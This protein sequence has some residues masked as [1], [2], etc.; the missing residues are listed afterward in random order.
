MSTKVSACLIAISLWLIA[1]PT[2]A[3]S[4]MRLRASAPPPPGY[5][6]FCLRE[7]LECGGAPVELL[8]AA[9]TA[10]HPNPA[11]LPAATR[12][13]VR[14]SLTFGAI[15]HPSPRNGK[16][17][18]ALTPSGWS[19][20]VAINTR[21]NKAV[22]PQAD[23]VTWG[24][25]DY[26]ALPTAAGDCEDYVLEKR[27]EL[28][29]AGFLASGLNIAIVQMVTGEAHAVLLVATREG[30]FVL[31][32]LSPWIRPWAATGYTWRVRQIDGQ[33]FNWAEVG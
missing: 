7:P 12:P 14:L 32:N 1:A 18:D 25:E 2:S 13:K 15:F 5:V 28:L 16:D 26:W 20:L 6:A 24:V 19:Q 17:L 31:D 11:P 3:A 23:L 33:A 21:V 9:V 22:R 27:R 30:D 8:E 4:P 10:Q 29:K